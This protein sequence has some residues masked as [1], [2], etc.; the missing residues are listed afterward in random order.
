MKYVVFL[1]DGMSDLPNEN[2]G[3]K[4]PLELAHKPNIDSLAS[5]GECGMVRTIP[6]GMP[7]GSDTANLSVLG[8]DIRHCYTG[9]SPLEAV[10]I[11]INLKDTDVTLRC[12]L[13]S[14]EG[15]GDYEDMTMLDY[16]SDEIST[17]EAGM[18]IKYLNKH[19]PLDG[20]KF[21]TGISYRHCL[22]WEN[23]HTGF[24]FTPP[25]DI[26]TKRVGDYIL[27]D[28]AGKRFTELMKKSFELLDNHPVNIRRRERGLKPANS[29]WLWGEGTKPKL[30]SFFDLYGVT[31]TVVSAVDLIK[32]IGK[33][34]GLDVAEVPGATGNIDTN[35]E[36]KAKAALSALLSGKDFV[37]IHVEAPDECGHRQEYENKIHSIELIDEKIVGPVVKG[38]EEAGESYRVL[39]LPDHP[40]PLALRTHTADPVPYVLFDSRREKKGVESYTEAKCTE[41]GIF[42]EEGRT[43]MGTFLKG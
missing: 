17:R 35:F 20:M 10:S 29:I 36:G 34:A 7:T 32:G 8:Y 19:L 15:E 39:I 4:T 24:D 30:D 27:K 40:T 25:H 37:F 11:G 12:N 13:V 42:I 16:S 41:T 26:L 22:V 14:L 5:R 31:G 2:L 18:L 28:G 1:G 43:L 33:C 3:G 6:H 21:Y 23:G 9:R 38:L